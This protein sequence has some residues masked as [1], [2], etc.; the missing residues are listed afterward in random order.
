MTK[1]QK[2]IVAGTALVLVGVFVVSDFKWLMPKDKKK[3]TGT[4]NADGNPDPYMMLEVN[5]KEFPNATG[6][7]GC[8]TINDLSLKK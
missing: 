1:T 6:N 8:V 7:C 2:I 3:G 5:E 4:S